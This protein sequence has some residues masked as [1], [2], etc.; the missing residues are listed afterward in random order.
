MMSP[1][2]RCNDEQAQIPHVG[3]A[4]NVEAGWSVFECR[5]GDG[6][7]RRLLGVAGNLGR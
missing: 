4:A 3:K 5:C 2:E 6:R 7:L 1:E